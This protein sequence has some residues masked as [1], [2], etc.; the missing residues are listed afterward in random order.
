MNADWEWFEHIVGETAK[1]D[2]RL[3]LLKAV[4]KLNLCTRSQYDAMATRLVRQQA[5]RRK[6]E[7]VAR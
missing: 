4:F 7:R 6:L 1:D 3:A 5:R 2:R